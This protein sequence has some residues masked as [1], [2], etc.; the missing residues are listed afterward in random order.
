MKRIGVI[1]DTHGRL[2]E[3]VYTFF[4]DCDEIWHAGDCGPNV[5][6]ELKKFKPIRAVWGNVDDYSM[7]YDYPKINIFQCE[8]LKIMMT[9]IGGYPKRYQPEIRKLI[10]QEKP[11]IFISGHS[12]ILKIMYDQEFNLLHI[13]P[14]AAGRQGFQKVDTLVR[15]TIDTTPKDLEILNFPKF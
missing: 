9:H 10:I 14:G 8:N 6:E 2:P 13:N 15:F 12:H 7:H 3:Q 4:K 11:D 1:S 5:I